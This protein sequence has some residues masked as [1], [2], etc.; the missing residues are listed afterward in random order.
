MP[1]AR[2]VL[3]RSRVR[4][5]KSSMFVAHLPEDVGHDGVNRE[6]VG[7]V[8]RPASRLGLDLGPGWG[9]VLPI[10]A[11]RQRE[12]FLEVFLSLAETWARRGQAGENNDRRKHGTHEGSSRLDGRERSHKLGRSGAR[13][14]RTRRG[15][16]GNCQLVPSP[17]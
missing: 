3:G 7:G 17:R 15:E 9:V 12:E 16:G 14:G 2:L 11:A 13:L 4:W 10:V 1:I 8:G 5:L 6:W